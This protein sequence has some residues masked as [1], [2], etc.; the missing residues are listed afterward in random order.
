MS[1]RTNWATPWALVLYG[2][3]VKGQRPRTRFAFITK[4]RVDTDRFYAYTTSWARGTDSWTKHPR[5][6]LRRE[7]VKMWRHRPTRRALK[8]A[9][10]RLKPS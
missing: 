5:L 2:G 8:Q 1:F 7:I 3:N 9:Q 10:Q 4:Y 6:F